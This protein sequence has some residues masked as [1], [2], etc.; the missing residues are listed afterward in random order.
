MKASKVNI[1]YEIMDCRDCPFAKLHTG[2]GECW[3]ECHHKDHKQAAY[4]N[5]LWGCQ[6]E[7][8]RVPE[9]CPLGLAGKYAP[10]NAAT[11]PI[12]Q[13]PDSSDCVA[14]VAAMATGTSI[15][16]FKAIFGHPGPY[17]TLYLHLYLTM[18]GLILGTGVKLNEARGIDPSTEL[19][20]FEL[21]LE[22]KPAYIGVK[23]ETGKEGHAIYWDGKQ[24]FDPSPETEN[25]RSLSSYEVEE[26]QL[27]TRMEEGVNTE[28][29]YRIGDAVAVLLMERGAS[30]TKKVGPDG[31]SNY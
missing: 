21:D 1:E 15:E 23:S 25:G 27:I 24:I 11:T 10:K 29:L 3:T 16:R 18:H 13:A 31:Y 7:F 4:E 14:A 17:S 6:E 2:H 5:I 12:K 8:K 19:F 20:C 28:L 26:F 9:W 30:P 22:G